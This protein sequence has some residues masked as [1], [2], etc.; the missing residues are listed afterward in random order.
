MDDLDYYDMQDDLEMREIYASI[1]Y[2][3]EDEK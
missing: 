1:Y 3:E 2:T